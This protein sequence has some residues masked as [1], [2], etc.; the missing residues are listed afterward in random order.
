[1]YHS[2]LNSCYPRPI[3][4][5]LYNSRGKEKFNSCVLHSPLIWCIN[6]V[7]CFHQLNT[8][9]C[10]RLRQSFKILIFFT[11]NELSHGRALFIFAVWKKY[12]RICHQCT[13]L[14]HPPCL[15][16][17]N[18]QAIDIIHDSPLQQWLS[19]FSKKIFRRVII[20]SDLLHCTTIN[21]YLLHGTES[22]LRS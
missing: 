11:E 17:I 18:L 15:F 20:I 9:T 2:I 1:M 22:F 21:T 8:S 6:K 14:L 12:L 4:C 3:F 13:S 7:L 16:T 5:I 10:F 19:S